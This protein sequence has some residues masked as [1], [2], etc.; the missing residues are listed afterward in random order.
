MIVGEAYQEFLRF[1]Q[2]GNLT[3]VQFT[4]FKWVAKEL[5]FKKFQIGCAMTLEPQKGVRPTAGSTFDS[6]LSL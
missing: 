3:R 2:M 5:V 4:E 6:S 1:C